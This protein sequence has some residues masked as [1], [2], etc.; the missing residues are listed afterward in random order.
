MGQLS[1]HATT[2]EAPVASIYAL[3]QEKPPQWEAC[4]PHLEKARRQQQRPSAA[5]N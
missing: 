5:K 2:A 4:A 1:L 3:Q